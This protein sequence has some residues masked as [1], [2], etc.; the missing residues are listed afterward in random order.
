[1]KSPRARSRFQF[2]VTG[3]QEQLAMAKSETATKVKLQ[4]T[5]YDPDREIEFRIH[6]LGQQTRPQEIL[7]QGVRISRQ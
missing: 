2:D 5:N 4:F 6:A 7:F 3:N 1:M